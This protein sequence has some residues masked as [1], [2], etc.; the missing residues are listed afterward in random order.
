MRPYISKSPLQTIKLAS[1]FAKQLKAGDIVL[2]EGQLGSG[3]T[4]FVKGL[5]QGLKAKVND[6]HSPTFVLMNIYKGK[7][8]IY[9]F[10]LYR[11]QKPQELASLNWDEYLEADG[12]AVIEWPRRLGTQIPAHGY[13]IEF[14]HQ[15]EN[16]RKI[17]ISY[18]WKPQRRFSR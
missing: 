4:T 14:K 18:R 5:A 17:C 6:V 1:A 7:F 12:V 8:P 3:K 13:W 2:L 10:D 9:H 15:D 16:S 11:L